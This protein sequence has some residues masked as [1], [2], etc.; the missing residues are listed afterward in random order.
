MPP[1][2][3]GEDRD[4]TPKGVEVLHE[5]LEIT[6]MILVI[7]QFPSSQEVGQFLSSHVVGQFPSK[8]SE[9]LYNLYNKQVFCH[10]P[11]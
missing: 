5:G 3:I 8:L 6:F 11:R 10:F 7:G 4:D 9:I 1:V 2:H